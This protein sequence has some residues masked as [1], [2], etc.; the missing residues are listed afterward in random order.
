MADLDEARQAKNELKAALDGRP[1]VSAIGI[2][3]D[4]DGY[5][6]LVRVQG[7]AVSARRLDVPE[8]VRGVAVHVRPTGPITAQT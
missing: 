4:D 5:G 6:L 8:H 7:D 3:R 1:D 2:S